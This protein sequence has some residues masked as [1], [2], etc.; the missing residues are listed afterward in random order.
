MKGDIDIKL[1]ESLFAGG[2]TQ[3]YLKGHTICDIHREIK[4]FRWLVKGSLDYFIPLQES[5]NEILVCQISEPMSTIGLGGLNAPRRYTYK[6][7]VSSDSATFFEIAIDELE[8][9]LKKDTENKLFKSISS[10]LYHQLRA[11][12]LKQMDLLQ[13]V[14][15][16]PLIGDKEFF[17]TPETESTEVISLMRCS[18]FLD[19]FNEDR[20]SKLASIAERREYEPYEILYTQDHS[21][22]G[23][24]ILID[25]EVSIKRI[26]G[27]IEIKQ[28]AINNS[29]FIFGWSSL[30]GEKDIC[31][32]M[33]TKKTAT[34]FIPFKGFLELFSAD[35][36]FERQFHKRLLWLIGNQINAAFLRFVGLLGKHNLQ[37]VFQL[38]E[39]NKSRLPLTSHLHQ[40]AHLLKNTTTKNL[41]YTALQ[42]LLS[43]GTSLERHLA[44]L[45]L[46]LLKDDQEELQYINGLHHIYETVALHKS[47]NP[48]EVR[49]ACAQ[50]TK[51]L[52][53]TLKYHIEGQENIPE[54][55]GNIFIYNHLVNDRYYTLNNNFQITLDSHFISAMILDEKY[56]E[57][58]IRTVRIG[59]GQE[60]GHQNY[61]KKLGHINVYTKES[62]QTSS[63]TKKESRS[64]F[65]KE[66]EQYLKKGYNLIISPEGTSYRTENS[67][68]PFKLGSF[69]LALNAQPEPNIIP[70]VLVNF[71]HRIKDTLYYCK[72]LPPFKISEYVERN[73]ID[74]LIDFVESYQ[75][76]YT[77]YVQQAR[78][79]ADK[80]KLNL[81]S[82][83]KITNPP[84]IWHNEIRRLKQRVAKL[85]HQNELTAFYGSSSIRLWVNMKKDLNPLHVL[86]LGFGGSSFAWCTHYF[87]EIFKDVNP[88]KIVLYAGENDLSEGRTPQEV[89][90]DCKELV[91]LILAKYPRAE[92]AFISLKPSVER[93]HLIPQIMETNLLLSKYVIGELNAQFINVFARM[94]TSD[95]RPRPELYLSDGLH[96]NKKGYTIWSNVIQE[97]LV[98][99]EQIFSE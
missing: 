98:I 1:L 58:G 82:Q 83:E 41:A 7:M 51:K 77:T 52:F 55:S 59:Q 70:I 45:S 54:K 72:I 92:L 97:A 32:A 94:I 57:P 66:S 44:S 85:E 61:Y 6:A 5:E 95:N 89:L 12:L 30:I 65:Y 48:K 27:N 17:M 13:P 91:E 88:S 4:K 8:E 22:N 28:R 25:G 62:A 99:S 46:E 53:S 29:G 50:A 18:P 34:Y 49:K 15:F 40:V 39:N 14:R 68:G 19:Q 47:D 42:Q 23:L 69:K 56:G 86:N 3:H 2:K 31:S 38:I 16:H 75:K 90:T 20:L 37:A 21:A 73:N 71:D 76:T 43:Q 33:T 26:E 84:E 87:T 60:Y 81:P 36:S 63:E 35:K 74:S 24:F 96:L 79:E 64:I 78:E 93:T 67:P 11:A 80:L 9:H 10:R